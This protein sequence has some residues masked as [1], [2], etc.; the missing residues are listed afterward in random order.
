MQESAM[1]RPTAFS[2]PDTASART[3]QA[4]AK[5]R[6]RQP[7]EREFDHLVQGLTDEEIA[8]VEA[9]LASAG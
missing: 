4:P 9:P 7:R 1:P 3:A 8:A 6:L 2:S 5:T